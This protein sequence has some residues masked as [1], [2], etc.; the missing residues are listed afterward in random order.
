MAE[1]PDTATET[2]TLS[3][4]LIIVEDDPLLRQ[5][6][7]EYLTL[8]GYDV[9]GVGSA[10]DFYHEVRT[11]HYVLAILDVGLP[12]QSGLVLAEYLRK[13]SSLRI[14]MLTALSSS[15]DKFAGYR[16]GVDIY[17]TKPVDCRELAASIGNLIERI[18]AAL[19]PPAAAAAASSW[20]L[21]RSTWELQTPAGDTIS[22]TAKEFEFITCLVAP[23]QQTTVQRQDALKALGYQLNEYG[24]RSLE[25]L[26]HRLRQKVEAL[27]CPFPVKTSRGIGYSF[28]ADLVI[29]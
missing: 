5:D 4:R 20:K 21:L 10:A 7:I 8:A 17:M 29:E 19:P 16:S 27:N 9:T 28:T 1:I 25:A 6:M 11:H 15:D 22:L 14:I 23:N 3:K 13:N 24:N 18:T 2:G 12:D 26:V